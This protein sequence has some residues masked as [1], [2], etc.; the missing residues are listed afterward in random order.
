VITVDVLRQ[1]SDA[2]TA[3][4]Q[5]AKFAILS[6]VRLNGNKMRRITARCVG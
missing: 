4:L 2:T 5:A 3:A 6:V 1:Q